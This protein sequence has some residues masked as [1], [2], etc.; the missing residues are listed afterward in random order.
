MTQIPRD[1]DTASITQALQEGVERA[2]KLHRAFG[3][4]LCIWSDERIQWLDPDTLQPV[5]EPTL[6]ELPEELPDAEGP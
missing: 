1:V 3:V 2:R 5:P 6:P 4:P